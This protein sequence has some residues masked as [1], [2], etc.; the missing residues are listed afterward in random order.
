M[1]QDDDWGQAVSVI[2]MGILGCCFVET[3]CR[4]FACLLACLVACVE[5]EGGRVG[6]RNTADGAMVG[7]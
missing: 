6:K 7:G 1:S 5:G 3:V 2:A 4:Q